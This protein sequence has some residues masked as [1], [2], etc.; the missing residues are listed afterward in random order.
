[1]TDARTETRMTEFIDLQRRFHELSDSELE[2][3]ELLVS[4]SGYEFGP[5]FGWPPGI[6]WPE[7]LEYAR[8][9]LL[10]EAGAGKTVEM[11]EQAH[12]LV[13]E[14][15]FAFFI[16]LEGLARYPIANTLSV[17]EEERFEQWKADGREPAWFFLDA[18]DELKLT[19]GKLDRALNRL[20]RAIDGCLDRA[21]IILSCRPSDWRSGSD[22]NTV[23]NRLPVPEVRRDSSVRSPED[24]FSDALGNE[25]GGQSRVTPEEDESPDQ[26]PVR[27]V[28]ML[29]I[30]D[31]QITHFAQ[32]R[33]LNDASAFLAEIERQEAWSFARRPFDLADLIGAWSS[34]GRLGTRAEQHEANIAAKLDDPKRPD[35][36]ILA[37]TKARLGAE[38]LALALALTRK[39]TI[40]S[41]DQTLD[42]RSADGVLDAATILPDWTPAE[43]QALLRRALFD[44]AT[45]GR[46]RFHHR[47]VQ[48][49]LAAQRLRGLHEQGMSIKALFR[50]LFAERYGA[51][52]VLPSMRAIAA[53]LAL[54]SD[55]VRKSL[56]GREPEALLSLGDPGS[57]DLTTRRELLRAFVSHYGRGDWRGLNIP[58]AEVRRLAHPELAMVIREC[59]EDGPA[60]EEVRDLLIDLIHL[61]PVRACADLARGIA[62][63]A[64]APAHHRIA[65]IRALLACGWHD[66]VRKLARSMLAEPTSWPD[67]VVHGVAPDLFPAIITADELVGLMERTREPKQSVGGFAWASRQIVESVEAG[68]DS[69]IDLRDRM[70]DLIRRGREQTHDPCFVRS[71]FDHL[72]P[73]LA[74]LCHR[75]LSATTEKP[76]AD[77]IRASVIASRFGESTADERDSVRKLRAHFSANAALRADAFW[78]E[79]AF[80]DDVSPSDDD[81]RR[82]R[83]AG[84][85]GL[86]GFLTE[87][88]RPWIEAALADERRPER[89]TVALHAWIDD[90]IRRGRVATELD[91]IRANLKEDAPL[92]RILER[93]TAPPEPN[94]EL[95]RME[96][97]HERRKRGQACRE[98]Q[99][100]EN[101]KRWR[102]ELLADPDDAFS[103]GKRQATVS[104]L[105]SW[106]GASAQNRNRFNRWNKNA[107]AQAFG[108]D[109]AGRAEKA[110][111]ALWRAAP[112][113]L[114]SARPID[115]RG[116]IR[117][118]WISGL[119]GVSTETEAETP[120]WTASLSPSEARTAVA[121]ATIELNGFAPFI[122]D[123]VESHP[124]EVEEVI[125]GEVRAELGMG[126]AYDHL[127]ALQDL[128]HADSRLKQL[129][130]PRLLAVLKS[131]P[132]DFAVDAGPRWARHLD[133]VLRI[134]SEASDATDRETIARECAGRYEADSLGALALAWLRGLFQL[135][136]DRGTQA[137][138]GGIESCKEA[139]SPDRTIETFA[140]LF[141]DRDAV[142]FE[143]EEPARRARLLGQLVR[144]A[145]AFV[146]PE[147]D[148]VH[149]GVY[150]PNTRDDAETAR[151]LLLS[152]LL[153]TP[154]PDAWRVLLELADE[155]DFAH[156]ADRLRF[157]ARQR[158][159]IDAEFLPFASEDV[160]ALDTRHEAPPRDSHGLFTVMMDRLDDLAHDLA[161]HDFTIRQTL[162][163][164]CKEPEIQRN[165]AWEFDSRANGVY[166]VT[167]EE[168]VAD[169][170]RTDI[171]LS[172]V[173][174]DLKAVIEVKIA[175]NDWTLTDLERAL[176]NQLV[177]QYLRHSSCR[178]GCLLLTC[179]GRK[180]YW[181][182]PRTRGRISFPELVAFLKEKARDVENESTHDVRVAVFGLD[183]T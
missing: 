15:R 35:R 72:A 142:A 20:S 37:D 161:H 82:L 58:L 18:V 89:R 63:D 65:A 106:L 111:R 152:M 3:T 80:M 22:L 67:R 46:V 47:S 16:P 136:A 5:Y 42:D 52:V 90:W 38:W 56:I 88:D 179:H 53:W 170:K 54:R 103:E 173:N 4:R 117:D 73:A 140:A 168:E 13:G 74:M 60:N 141:G 126:G 171:R 172:A 31:Q 50:L 48:E 7:L 32:C 138:I 149:E 135:D 25:H 154:G 146:R 107:L 43:R 41:P 75:Q 86:A 183:L 180:Q 121:Y 29:P 169:N 93:H 14:G 91:A 45:Y 113:V 128:T 122:T 167:R 12:R 94:E 145:Y 130:A 27:T 112:P 96:R 139:G 6:G 61:G 21:R 85:E 153:D 40:R 36:G 10:A 51:E 182:H 133:R 81:W 162:Q 84:H 78:A 108:Q 166:V 87:A 159:A 125:G 129:L 114:W 97:E 131:W 95:E 24:V 155:D 144:Y 49:Y 98:A 160:V 77:L 175:D 143:V 28:A 116:N 69:A 164:I 55:A 124:E 9:I 118:D 99:R 76:P 127:P 123:L 64:A 178:A 137:L 174:G 66:S 163:R 158:A 109:I 147:D 115:E 1:M 119:T 165:L 71:E 101:W 148:Q 2:D 17:A 120:G 105:Y 79:L 100:R 19:E 44:P 70:A 39:R 150:T 59:W 134:L 30:S 33:G 110:F 83:Q 26:S 11:Q 57:L 157:Q 68:S 177:G 104:N 156:Q 8:V 92:V 176:A 151:R 62:L 181:V 23:R 102:D 132:T 34:S